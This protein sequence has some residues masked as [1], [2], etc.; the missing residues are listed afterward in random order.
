MSR[1][2]RHRLA[3]L[4]DAMHPP[5]QRIVFARGDSPEEARAYADRQVAA[6]IEIGEI[7]SETETFC[8]LTVYEA[9]P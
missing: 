8:F 1:T 2:T 5:R 6:V 4:E 9:R 7:R 3:R